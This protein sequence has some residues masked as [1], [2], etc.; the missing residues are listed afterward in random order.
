[1]PFISHIGHV[2]ATW[3]AQYCHTRTTVQLLPVHVPVYVVF[4]LLQV[5]YYIRVLAKHAVF[6]LF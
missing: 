2:T 5:N 4:V 3:Y 6:L 1:M